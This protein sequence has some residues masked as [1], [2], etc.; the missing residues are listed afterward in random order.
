[1][2][3]LYDGFV[4]GGSHTGGI[5]RYF[6]NL[7]S[8]LPDEAE[9]WVTTSHPP[10]M[11][12]P[13]HPKLHVRRSWRAR[14]RKLSSLFAQL[15]FRAVERRN[16][17]DV[18]HPTYYSLMTRRRVRHYRCPAVI[19]V[20]DMIGELFSEGTAADE[21]A[22]QR[23]RWAIDDAQ[24]IICVSQNTKRDLIELFGIAEEK[25]QVVYEASELRL[26]M[27]E[28]E[29][30]RS[31]RP[32]FLFV[33]S[34]QWPYKNFHGL[35]KGFRLVVERCADALLYFAGPPLTVEQRNQIQSL[36][37]RENIVEA[38]RVSDAKLAALYHHSVALVYPSL[39]EGFGIP[40]LEAMACETAV[41]ASNRSSIPE[42]VGDAALLVDPEN[43]EEL[44]AAMIV[45]LEDR[46]LRDDLIRRGRE[47][48]RLFSWDKMAAEIYEIYRRVAGK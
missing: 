11:H 18:A 17:F 41:I 4:F 38:G 44:S 6:T 26:S 14:S 28:N 46:K 23:K 24:S 40:P 15:R 36:R 27:A 32:Y 34:H 39:Y 48:E 8:R 7:I 16:D 35:L 30:P 25:V 29:Y 33:G 22:T 43:T 10:S 3:I 45:L 12:F 42:V 2:R 5:R 31:E 13:S 37:L 21:L 9:P 1:V 19:T 47:R 20:H